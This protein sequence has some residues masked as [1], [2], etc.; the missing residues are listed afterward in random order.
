MG[1]IATSVEFQILELK[2]RGMIMDLED[3]KV[4]EILLDIG[5][6][7]LGFYCNPFEVD[8]QHKL[9]KGTKFSEVLAL[10]YMDVDL[11]HLLIKYLNRVET[12]FKT[13]LIYYISNKYKDDNKWFVNP[14]VVTVDFIEGRFKMLPGG[15]EANYRVGGFKK[16]IYTAS[17]KKNNLPIRNHHNKHKRCNYAPAWK[18]IEFLTF[19]QTTTIYKSLVNHNE[20]EYLSKIYEIESVSKFEN[21]LNMLVDLRNACSHG[22]VLFDYQTKHAIS[23]LPFL[24]IEKDKNHSLG[25]CF[26]ILTFF[27]NSISSNRKDDFLLE[28]RDLFMS[29]KQQYPQ[30]LKTI[31][32]TI[33][34]KIKY[35][36]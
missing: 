23:S 15:I 4:R 30:N 25:S 7:R 11:R 29:I 26:K 1:D 17:F 28:L 9:K 6:Y 21:F 22:N 3:F 24:E 16:S 35:N 33:I 18:T 27:I 5:H 19:G 36:V 2:D 13:N 31:D 32:E 10:Y 12:N 20:K 34:N 14:T 8:S